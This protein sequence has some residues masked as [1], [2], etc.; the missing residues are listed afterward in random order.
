M[1]FICTFILYPDLY[2]QLKVIFN[3]VTELR[4]ISGLNYDDVNGVVVTDGVRQVWNLLVQVNEQ[5]SSLLMVSN[6]Q[7]LLEPS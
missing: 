7:S 1:Y 3:D 2:D 5:M 6:I 4:S